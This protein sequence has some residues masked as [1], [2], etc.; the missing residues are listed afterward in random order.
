[1]SSS[2]ENEMN[3][4]GNSKNKQLVGK[5]TIKKKTGWSWKSLESQEDLFLKIVV[6]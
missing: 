4:F 6:K 1:M 3:K 2:R 5:F